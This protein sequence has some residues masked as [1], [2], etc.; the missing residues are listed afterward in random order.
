MPDEP[1]VARAARADAAAATPAGPPASTPPGG[2][3]CCDEQ[4]RSR[5][6]RGG[7]AEG[8]ALLPAARRGPAGPYQLQAAIAAV[9]PGRDGRGMEWTG[10]PTCT[11]RC[12]GRALAG[13]RGCNRAVAV[14]MAHGPARGLAAGALLADLRWPATSCCTRPAPSCCAGAAGRGGGGRVR[15]DR[16]GRQCRRPRPAPPPPDRLPR[17]ASHSPR[18]IALP[19]RVALPRCVALPAVSHFPAVTALPAAPHSPPNRT[20]RRTALPAQGRSRST[21]ALAP[22]RSGAGISIPAEIGPSMVGAALTAR[23]PITNAICS[24]TWLL[25]YA[26]SAADSGPDTPTA[27]TSAPRPGG[28]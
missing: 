18:R 14:G 6:D 13:G 1:E 22:F 25:V 10:S 3:S 28:C 12:P 8:L 27:M 11:P 7:V 4:D 19:R 16:A 15:G 26:S 24:C 17:R 9:Q 2:S 21:R 20:P 23:P 5:W